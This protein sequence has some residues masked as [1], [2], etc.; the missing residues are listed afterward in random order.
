MEGVQMNHFSIKHLTM[1]SPKRF[2]QKCQAAFGHYEQSCKI[3]S[4][5]CLSM[6]LRSVMRIRNSQL[7]NGT[8][9]FYAVAFL[10]M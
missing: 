4:F 1:L 9:T 5:I 2:Y 3:S 6:L 7:E 8:C 10:T